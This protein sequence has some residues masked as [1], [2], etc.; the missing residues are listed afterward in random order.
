MRSAC[1]R[2]SS[3]NQNRFHMKHV[4]RRTARR[5]CCVTVAAPQARSAA[6]GNVRPARRVRPGGTDHHQRRPLWPRPPAGS[7]GLDPSG[8]S[9]GWGPH[10]RASPLCS[11]P[12]EPEVLDVRASV[13]TRRQE[14]SA[15]LLQ[16]TFR[17]FFCFV[18]ATNARKT[19]LNG[20]SDRPRRAPPPEIGCS[21]ESRCRGPSGRKM[22]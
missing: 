14:D 16:I 15:D 11:A 10:G 13:F 18:L 19:R 6:C 8:S 3:L 7:S 9:L 12:R 5:C 2:V 22:S 4:C 17:G 1:I 21:A 20:E